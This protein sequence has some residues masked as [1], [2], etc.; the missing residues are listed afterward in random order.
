MKVG[1]PNRWQILR[2]T[3]L[4][5]LIFCGLHQNANAAEGAFFFNATIEYQL[6]DMT[7]PFLRTGCTDYGFQSEVHVCTGRNPRNELSG[8]YEFAFGDFRKKWYLP[9]IQVG[10]KHRS[11]IRDG[12]PFNNRPEMF[13][14]LLF[15]GFKL[16]G[17]R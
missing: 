12:S 10:Y 7:D 5:A 8:G 15:I 13:Q 6:D 1:Q 14:D 2:M 17:L 3:M 4:I 9:I 16:G 11:G